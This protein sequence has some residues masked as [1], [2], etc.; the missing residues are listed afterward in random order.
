MPR[1]GKDAA[2]D[3]MAD[4][5]DHLT[6][7]PPE[8]LHSIC[9]H[10]LPRHYPDAG[11][12]YDP[13]MYFWDVPHPLKHLSATCRS[14]YGEVNSWAL[15]F[16]RQHASITNYKDLKTKKLQRKRNFLVGKG[17][18]IPWMNKHCIFCGK[19]SY[20]MAI[21]VSG[22]KCCRPCDDKQWPN[23]ITKT[24]AKEKY[25]L[26]DHH[27]LPPDSLSM[28]KMAVSPRRPNHLPRIR[29]GSYVTSNIST[30]MFLEDD[31]R[32]L[33]DAVHGDFAA[34]EKRKLEEA[35]ERKRR[36]AAKEKKYQA[37]ERAWAER[38]APATLPDREGKSREHPI[39]IFEDL[40]SD[41]DLSTGMLAGAPDTAFSL[42]TALQMGDTR[43]L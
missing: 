23:K 18:L 15:H 11:F 19:S 29:Y 41:G 37:A 22:F 16:L 24:G 5:K 4:P 43:V 40:I 17:G 26:R 33:A 31:V 1:Q 6:A 7:L 3:L 13:H 32:T 34:H 38:N 28:A 30:T 36:R 8:L 20:R 39:E 12:L 21:L 10:L 2:V 35:E 14:L 25:G 27:L 9:D 42:T